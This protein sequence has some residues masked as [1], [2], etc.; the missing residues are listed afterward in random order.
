M[1][2]KVDLSNLPRG[3][4]FLKPTDINWKN[5][6]G[7]KIPFKYNNIIGE[8]EVLH[9]KDSVLT[10]KYENII[11]K[12]H[13]RDIKKGKIAKCIGEYTKEYRFN[14]DTIFKT[15]YGGEIK[16]TNRYR[17]NDKNGEKFYEYLCLKC[18]N[19][20][21]ISESELKNNNPTCNVCSGRKTLKGV[22][23]VATTNP[24]CIDYL[25][26]KDDSYLYSRGSSKKVCFVCPDCNLEKYMTFATFIKNGIMCNRCGDGISFPEKVIYN[27]LKQLKIDFTNQ[28]SKTT[29][30]WCGKYRYDFYIPK[31]NMII[32]THGEQHY[33]KSWTNESVEYI[34]DNDDKK[35]RLAL[36]NGI[37]N[38][39]ILDCRNSE[40][41]WIKKSIINSK[42]NYLFDLTK[43]DWDECLKYSSTNVYK[44]ICSIRNET[45]MTANQ[46]SEYIDR[47]KDLVR[48]ALKIGSKLGWCIYDPEDEKI[49]KIKRMSKGVYVLEKDI[50]FK[51]QSECS[52]KSLEYLEYLLGKHQY[53]KHA[54]RIL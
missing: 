36:D 28:L 16:I 40:I 24:E 32:E 18:G 3:G 45:G 15:K 2:N 27:L 29:F 37:E 17:D 39:V 20:D 1:K 11:S 46:I 6:V 19:T 22:N 5:S 26:N 38:Y 9:W 35:E 8:I 12:I 21:K 49:K 30:D 31:Y 41:E 4:K 54:K 25:K 34:S 13:I 7:F 52:K 23:D 33:N 14:I 43:I 10:V 44:E 50:K 42:L 51:S 53:H 47:S 48:Y